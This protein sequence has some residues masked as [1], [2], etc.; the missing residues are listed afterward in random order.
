MA[1][2]LLVPAQPFQIAP[3]PVFQ[4]ASRANS[5]GA[6]LLAVSIPAD[7]PDVE[8]YLVGGIE[9]GQIQWIGDR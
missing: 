4:F 8:E 9:P 2:S 5:G 1:G 6:R 3:A 7:T